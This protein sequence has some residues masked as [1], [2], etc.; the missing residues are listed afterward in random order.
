M[1]WFL[2]LP[3]TFMVLRRPNTG[4][5]PEWI[6]SISDRLRTAAGPVPRGGPMV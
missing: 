5:A 2:Y 6:S 3:A 1:I 4:E